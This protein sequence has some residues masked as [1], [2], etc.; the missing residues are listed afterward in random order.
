MGHL[1]FVNSQNRLMDLAEL[2][3]GTTAAV[4]PFGSSLLLSSD[5]GLSAGKLRATLRQAQ[6]ERFFAFVASPP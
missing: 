3:F 2:L 1:L 5:E 6:G 4:R